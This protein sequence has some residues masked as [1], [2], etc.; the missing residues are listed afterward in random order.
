MSGL[1]VEDLESK[2]S[3]IIKKYPGEI[4]ELKALDF[5]KRPVEEQLEILIAA[6]EGKESKTIEEKRKSIDS[7]LIKRR[8]NFHLDKLKYLGKL[9]DWIDNTF[10]PSN[11]SKLPPQEQV[12]YLDSLTRFYIKVSGGSEQVGL[13]ALPV[14]VTPDA[15]D[16]NSKEWEEIE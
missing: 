13:S 2:S 1:D 11:V 9:Q 14:K 10:H 5:S 8:I 12:K 6:V 4:R 3:D 15:L 16:L 7:Y